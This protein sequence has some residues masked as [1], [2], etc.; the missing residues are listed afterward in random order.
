MLCFL[1]I[2]LKEIQL[3]IAKVY[4]NRIASIKKKVAT[5]DQYRF[6]SIERDTTYLDTAHDPERI[7]F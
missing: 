6:I 7:Q 4:S 2:K 5:M 1:K 3:E